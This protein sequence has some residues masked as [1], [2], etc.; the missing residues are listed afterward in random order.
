M[1]AITVLMAIIGFLCAALFV[2]IGIH[3]F[4]AKK[5]V[6]FWAGTKVDPAKVS[7]IRAYNRANG[8]M[9]LIFSVPF[10]VAGVAGLFNDVSAAASYIFLIALILGGSVGLYWMLNRYQKIAERY[11][12]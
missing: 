7:D 5:P 11:F 8:N 4:L 10:W 3:A 6:S 9:W 12:C 1:T 2:G